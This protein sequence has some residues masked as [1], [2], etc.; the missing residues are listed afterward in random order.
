MYALKACIAI[1]VSCIPPTQVLWGDVDPAIDTHE[2]LYYVTNRH[3]FIPEV[4]DH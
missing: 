2:M 3:K 4:R 1:H